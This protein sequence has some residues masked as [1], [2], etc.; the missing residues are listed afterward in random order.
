MHHALST[1]GAAAEEGKCQ[2]EQDATCNTIE[3]S[4]WNR[5]KFLPKKRQTNR[6][7]QGKRQ[8]WN[9]KRPS[10]AMGPVGL[11]NVVHRDHQRNKHSC[12]LGH[13]RGKAQESRDDG[14]ASCCHP[15]R[16]K[17]KSGGEDLSHANDA[18]HSLCA[19]M[20]VYGC[21]RVCV[22]VVRACVCMCVYV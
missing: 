15:K 8:S 16:Q 9:H 3:K 4:T 17:P 10:N 14:V 11:A 6:E 22:R 18:V 19:C 20:C 7:E 1:C 12:L 5:R 2:C 21:V 13:A